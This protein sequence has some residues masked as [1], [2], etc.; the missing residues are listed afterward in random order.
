MTALK[1]APMIV[2]WG[3]RAEG[4]LEDHAAGDV[5][6]WVGTGPGRKSLGAFPDRQSA[7]RAVS[8]AAEARRRLVDPAP[9]YASGLPR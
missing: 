7:M 4:E 2:Y 9:P 3:T 5:R 8:S 1:P 6:A